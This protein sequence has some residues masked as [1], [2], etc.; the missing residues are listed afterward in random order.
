LI[1][2]NTKFLGCLISV[3]LEEVSIKL[4]FSEHSDLLIDINQRDLQLIKYL[5]VSCNHMCTFVHLL[6]AIID[7][8]LVLFCG[9]LELSKEERVRFVVLFDLL[10][11][12][13][14]ELSNFN[15]YERDIF[16]TH[17][18]VRLDYVHLS[19]GSI[20]ALLLL[21]DGESKELNVFCELFLERLL[22]AG[23]YSNYNKSFTMSAILF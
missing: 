7:E 14:L 18:H 12:L 16:E 10:V 5:C 11:T 22:I 3:D 20:Y 13:L 23:L 9:E 17:S 6:L 4:S 21:R 19:Q 1:S 8:V 15:L 2:E